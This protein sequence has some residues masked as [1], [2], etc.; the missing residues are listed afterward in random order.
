[1]KRLQKALISFG[2]VAVIVAGSSSVFAKSEASKGRFISGS[3]VRIERRT[4]TAVVREQGSGKEINVNVPADSI[5]RTTLTGSG[6]A[7]FEQLT[8]GMYIR[9]VHVH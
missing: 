5:V 8:V 3:V 7:T 2:I 9:N 4:R 6:F 1:M